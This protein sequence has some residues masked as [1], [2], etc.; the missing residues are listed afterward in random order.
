MAIVGNVSSPVISQFGDALSDV[1]RTG[2][3][4][5]GKGTQDLSQAARTPTSEQAGIVRSSSRAPRT[6]PPDVAAKNTTESRTGR[7]MPDAVKVTVSRTAQVA[8][9]PNPVSVE[10]PAGN[11]SVESKMIGTSFPGVSEGTGNFDVS[12]K[13]DIKV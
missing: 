1:S 7:S 3:N 2:L 4:S 9:N 8:R 5:L 11:L 12:Q 13:V 10:G 6:T